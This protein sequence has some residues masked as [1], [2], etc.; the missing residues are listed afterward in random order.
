[1]E[2]RALG[3]CGIEV[4]A[5]GLGTYRVFHVQGDADIARC[6]AVVDVAVEEGARFADSS[7]MYGDAEAVL[8]RCLEDRRDD[9]LVATKVWARTRAVGEEQIERALEWFEHVDLYQVHN[10]LGLEDH[11]PYLRHL[12]D[13]GRVRAIGVTHYLPSKLP[14]IM[15]LMRERAV[16]AVQVPYHPGERAI[17]NQ[18]LPEAESSG[19]GVV[20]MSPFGGGRLL[21][22]RPEPHELAPLA[23]FG[24]F[25]WAQALLKWIVSDPRVSSVIPA[26]SSPDRMRENAAAGRA[27]FFTGEERTYVRQI[28]DRLWAE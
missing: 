14:E 15:D 12:R 28:F 24:V 25:T 13:A 20:V 8:A 22:R 1:M 17:E 7:P 9:V 27:P 19:I 23:S 18:L 26:T 11:L 21:E 2:L 3:R 16:D 10:L 6:E 4:P 5:V